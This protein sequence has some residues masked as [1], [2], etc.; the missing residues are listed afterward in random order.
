MARFHLLNAQL[1]VITSR[2]LFLDKACQALVKLQKKWQVLDQ[3]FLQELEGSQQRLVNRR[4]KFQVSKEL[5]QINLVG[6][7]SGKYYLVREHQ[8]SFVP[9]Q[10]TRLPCDV[11]LRHLEPVQEKVD[12]KMSYKAKLVERR[13][14]RHL[15]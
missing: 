2:A 15:C 8:Y 7:L 13:Q 10:L 3:A 6:D 14:S 11:E 4:A 1:P 9:R 12:A 5:D